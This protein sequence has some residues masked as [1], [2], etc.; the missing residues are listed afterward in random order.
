MLLK[1]YIQ[2][3]LALW[4]EDWQDYPKELENVTFPLPDENKATPKQKDL[5]MD[6]CYNVH[7][8]NFIYWTFNEK[9]NVMIA[10]VP[11]YLTN[12]QGDLERFSQDN[13]AV[14]VIKE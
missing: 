14:V 2:K 8:Q 1:T 13:R 10:E 12:I 7:I 9:N 11:E 5:Y 4:A 3:P 6:W